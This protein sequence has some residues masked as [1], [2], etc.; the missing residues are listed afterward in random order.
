MLILGIDPGVTGA[1]AAVMD[2]RVLE[3][4]DMPTDALSK[5]KT[6]KHRVSTPQLAVVLRDLR[7]RHGDGA[8]LAVV[9]QVGSMPGQGVASVFSLG[10]TAGA[11]RGVLG[12]LGLPHEFVPPQTWKKHFRLGK[13]KDESRTRAMELL[14]EAVGMLARKK[15]HNRAE[16]CLLGLYGWEVRA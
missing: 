14:P 8:V 2:G 10:D 9:E 3:V 1:I 4:V 5:G 11:I 13:D 15:D 16:A 7:A 12:A 6:V